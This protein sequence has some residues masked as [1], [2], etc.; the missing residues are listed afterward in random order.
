MVAPSGNSSTVRDLDAELATT[1]PAMCEFLPPAHG[2]LGQLQE[3]M[4]H[5]AEDMAAMN[6]MLWQDWRRIDIVV[7]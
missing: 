2:Q 3:C 1:Q 7:A 4:K 5:V 6:G